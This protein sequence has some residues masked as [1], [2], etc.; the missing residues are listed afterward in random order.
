MIKDLKSELSGNLE[1][2]IVALMTPTLEYKAKELHEAISGVGTNEKTLVELLCSA[3]NQEIHN[4]RA[5]YERRECW[6]LD[7][8]RLKQ[9]FNHRSY[10]LSLINRIQSKVLPPCDYN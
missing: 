9:L 6:M 2:L 8:E 7:Y 1:D 3:T 4:M 10:V 5:A